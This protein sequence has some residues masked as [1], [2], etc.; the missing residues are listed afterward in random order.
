VITDAPGSGSIQN[1]HL[2]L[3]YRTLSIPSRNAQF[4]TKDTVFPEVEEIAVN[5]VWKQVGQSDGPNISLNIEMQTLEIIKRHPKGIVKAVSLQ[6]LQLEFRRA[7][8]KSPRGEPRNSLQSGCSKPTTPCSQTN[9]QRAEST[10]CLL[11]VKFINLAK[12][13]NALDIEAICSKQ[14]SN[15]CALWRNKAALDLVVWEDKVEEV[16]NLSNNSVTTTRVDEGSNPEKD[17]FCFCRAKVKIAKLGNDKVKIAHK[18]IPIY[19]V[20]E[21]ESSEHTGGGITKFPGQPTAYCILQLDVADINPFLL[22]HELG[23][24]LGLP[25]S[26]GTIMEPSP[27]SGQP[28]PHPKITKNEC[29]FLSTLVSKPPLNS[30]I[31]TTGWDDEF[32]PDV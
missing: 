19:V 3:Y 1:L 16:L 31:V 26:I 18:Y 4:R 21:L 9:P 6:P 7:G 23:H 12:N 30:I 11:A 5:L 22:A 10:T 28:N 25:D 24:V 15:T 13:P 29:D 14:I 17:E 8:G 2:Q 20:D 32:C 27:K